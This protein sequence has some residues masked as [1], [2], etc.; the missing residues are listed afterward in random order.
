MSLHISV[1]FIRHLT[2]GVHTPFTTPQPH[3]ATWTKTPRHDLSPFTDPLK[4]STHHTGKFASGA[5][6]SPQILFLPPRL[7]LHPPQRQRNPQPTHPRPTCKLASSS[8]SASSS[9]TAPQRPLSSNHVIRE[10]IFLL[11]LEHLSAR[12]LQC[13]PTLRLR[14]AHR[15]HTQTATTATG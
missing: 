13:R 7:T 8:C 6:T 10:K 9:F 12:S 11:R 15:N 5:S 1:F 4:T 3:L 14:C 2:S